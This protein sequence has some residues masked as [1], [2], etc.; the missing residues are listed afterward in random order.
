MEFSVGEKLILKMQCEIYKHLKIKGEIDP[1]F[2]E[3]VLHSGHTW[4]LHWKYSGLFETGE[5]PQIVKEVLDVLEMWSILEGSYAKLSAEEKQFVKENA[6]PFGEHVKFRGF[7]GNNEYEHISVADFL[8]NHL[9]RFVEFK[10]RDLNSHA[11]SIGIY[12]RMYSVY[13]GIK[14]YRLLTA[15]QITDILKA[16]IH[17]DYR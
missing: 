11:P 4:G 9:D 12:K 17:P 6:A 3:E 5:N 14:T 8:I 15:E 2:V 7:D 13:D 10:G 16:M 1:A